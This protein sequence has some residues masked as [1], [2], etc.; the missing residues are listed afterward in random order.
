MMVATKLAETCNHN[1]SYFY[2]LKA[3]SSNSIKRLSSKAF[4]F[5]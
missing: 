1:V 4:G 2:L 3:E 5:E